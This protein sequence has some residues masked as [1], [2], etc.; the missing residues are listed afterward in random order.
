MQIH[1]VILLS[2]VAFAQATS[3]IVLGAGAS[4]IFAAKQ[5]KAA[6]I[7]VTILEA[8][9][10]AIG[11]RMHKVEFPPKSG[12]FVELGANWIEGL[13]SNITN[14]VLP[15][16]QKWGVNFKPSDFTNTTYRSASGS[17]DQSVFQDRLAAFSA[18]TE[19]T[20]ELSDK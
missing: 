4:G 9:P 3:V 10:D 1:S 6:G 8:R 16:V 11:G 17:F 13:G 5:L 19:M 12:R 7:D 20:S 14:P 18:I 2:L 15:L